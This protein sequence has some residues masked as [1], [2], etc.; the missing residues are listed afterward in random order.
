[1]LQRRTR[2][3]GTRLTCITSSQG[4]DQRTGSIA[5]ESAGCN[6]VRKE[7]KRPLFFSGE[8]WRIISNLPTHHL[9]LGD[10]LYVGLFLCS[11]NSN[12]VERAIFRDV[13]I[14]QQHGVALKLSAFIS[15]ICGQTQ[16]VS[17]VKKPDD[18]IAVLEHLNLRPRRRNGQSVTLGMTD[19]EQTVRRNQ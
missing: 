17:F 13:R 19:N 1:M 10:E 16:T 7:R 15:D 3:S 8:I 14:R 9:A 18:R 11:H 2:A 6:P 5:H 4:R 12:V